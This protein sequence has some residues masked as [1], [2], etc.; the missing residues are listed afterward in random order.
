MRVFQHKR[1]VLFELQVGPDKNVAERF[2]IV[3]QTGGI[4][5]VVAGAETDFIDRLGIVGLAS[6]D[7]KGRGNHYDL[8]AGT[9]G[10]CPNRP[11]SSIGNRR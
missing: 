10:K 5:A 2:G 3:E 6:A 8:V 9:V 4:M 11:A 7:V 1:Q